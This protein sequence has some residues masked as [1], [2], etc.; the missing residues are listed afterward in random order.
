LWGNKLAELAL[1]GQANKL[2]GFLAGDQ[3]MLQIIFPTN[4]QLNSKIDTIFVEPSGNRSKAYSAE[5]FSR[6]AQ[7]DNAIPGESYF[8]QVG[9]ADLRAGMKVTA[10]VPELAVNESG[11]IVPESALIWYMDQVYVYIKTSKDNF[12]RRMIKSFLKIP[13]GYFIA[14]DIQDGEAVVVTG[15]QL[16]LSEEM[17]GQIPDED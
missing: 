9:S 14:K 7:V 6:S 11:V 2:A 15:G 5:L 16:L 4:K 3:F 1:S 10:W 12:T 8:F 17:R 13:E